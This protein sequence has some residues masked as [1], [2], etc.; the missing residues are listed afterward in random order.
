MGQIINKLKEPGIDHQTLI[1][2]TADHGFDENPL[3]FKRT[4]RKGEHFNAPYV[5]LVTNDSQIKRHQGS[6]LDIAPTILNRFGVDLENINP[7]FS[8]VSLTRP[9]SSQEEISR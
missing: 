9:A 8:G 4:G 2:V 3:E 1:Y 6:Q 5:W 7:S